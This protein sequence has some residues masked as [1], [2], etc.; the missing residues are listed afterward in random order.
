M[1]SLS[2]EG[3]HAAE[4]RDPRRPPLY[5]QPSTQVSCGGRQVG[6]QSHTGGAT[7][8]CTPTMLGKSIGRPFCDGLGNPPDASQVPASV[9]CYLL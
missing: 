8:C 2:V 1:M 4:G 3:V 9:F 7:W 6:E 5:P